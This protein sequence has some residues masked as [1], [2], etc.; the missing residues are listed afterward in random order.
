M[1]IDQIVKIHKALGDRTR[2]LIMENV[3]NN[4]TSCPSKLCN[5]LDGVANSTLSHHLKILSDS[6]LIIPDKKG[7][8]IFYRYD[9]KLAQYF[10]PELIDGF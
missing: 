3:I 1:D 2:Y 9:K 8:Y 7:T 4:N 10:V 5:N 6:G